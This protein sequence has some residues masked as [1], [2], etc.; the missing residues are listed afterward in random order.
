MYASVCGCVCVCMHVCVDVPCIIVALSVR[1][2][3]K[4]SWVSSEG[5]NLPPS[6]NPC[7]FKPHSKHP[8][9]PPFS[10]P[11]QTPHLP[12]DQTPLPPL[13]TSTLNPSSPFEPFHFHIPTPVL[14]W[15][16]QC[17]SGAAQVHFHEGFMNAQEAV[18][19]GWRALRGVFR[20]WSIEE[21]EDLTVWLRGQGFADT[22]PGNHIAARAQ[23]FILSE[24]C[25][26]DARV[27][28]L[29]VSY[30][31]A[32][33]HIGRTTGG[34]RGDTPRAT[35]QRPC[36]QAVS[37]SRNGSLPASSWQ[38]SGGRCHRRDQRVEIVRLGA[39][40]DSAQLHKTSGT[41]TIGRD[42]LAA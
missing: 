10:T 34:P 12:P 1:A 8:S 22:R 7:P 19:T 6:L 9:P 21:R 40:D 30:V 2:P 35:I 29:G 28:L 24:A 16:V 33:L 42:E 20:L 18:R 37:G 26:V 17:F 25:R 27:A 13:S 3:G 5:V 14:Q 4:A 39:H 31:A 41:G 36:C 11:R 15:L 38:E 23:E 32:V